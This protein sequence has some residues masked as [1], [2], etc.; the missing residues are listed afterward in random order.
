[1]VQHITTPQLNALT[2]QAFTALLADVFEHSPWVAQRTAPM[3][4]FADVKALHEAMIKVLQQATDAERLI[5]GV[6]V[7]G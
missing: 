1:M 2:A 6:G 3:R 7:A 4:P 5:R